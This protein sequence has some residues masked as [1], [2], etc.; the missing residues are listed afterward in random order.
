ME[1]YP[2]VEAIEDETI[3][4]KPP[5][6]VAELSIPVDEAFETV[7]LPEDKTGLTSRLDTD[8]TEDWAMLVLCAADDGMFTDFAT[9]VEDV[10]R[11]SAEMGVAFEAGVAPTSSFETVETVTEAMAVSVT[12]QTVV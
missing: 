10:P 6:E 11:D 9:A 3:C 4:S 12:G 5:F 8:A 7:S 2:K 1:T